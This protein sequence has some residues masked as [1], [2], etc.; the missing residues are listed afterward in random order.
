MGKQKTG[1][2]QHEFPLVF[3]YETAYLIQL[4]GHIQMPFIDFS[5]NEIDFETTIVGQKKVKTLQIQ[6]KNPIPVKFKI[7]A[8]NT[9]ASKLLNKVLEQPT[10]AFSCYPSEC[11]LPSQSFVNIDIVFFH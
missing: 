7:S 6:N 1:E 9:R 3:Q 4:R 5:T 10:N 11:S 2:V 8:D